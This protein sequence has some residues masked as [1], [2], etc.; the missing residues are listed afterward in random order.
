ML[1]PYSCP[2]GSYGYAAAY[3]YTIKV[4]RYENQSVLPLKKCCF[5][6]IEK[7]DRQICELQNCPAQFHATS[8]TFSKWRCWD[9][10]KLW[11]PVGD[12]S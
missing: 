1:N 2:K 3:L 4:L 5:S 10:M 7:S 9:S 6:D 8:H 11:Q 12:K